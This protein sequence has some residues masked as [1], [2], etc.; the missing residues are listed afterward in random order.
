MTTKRIQRKFSYTLKSGYRNPSTVIS[1]TPLIS[2]SNYVGGL[3][4]YYQ[5]S[6]FSVPS[7]ASSSRISS[8]GIHITDDSPSS[9]TV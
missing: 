4:P 6:K 7:T 2:S 8:V 5:Q 1:L 9:D 3:R